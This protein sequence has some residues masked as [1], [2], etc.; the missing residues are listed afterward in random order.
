MMLRAELGLQA[1]KELE[2]LEAEGL[3]AGEVRGL[4]ALEAARSCAAPLPGDEV[5][6]LSRRSR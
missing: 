1:E 6:P 3:T 5:W 4:A 2:A